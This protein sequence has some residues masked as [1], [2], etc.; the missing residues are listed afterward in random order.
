MTFH[1]ELSARTSPV[2]IG[3]DTNAGFYILDLSAGSAL[4]GITQAYFDAGYTDAHAS[5][6]LDDRVTAP[7]VGLVLDLIFGSEGVQFTDPGICTDCGD[8][9]DHYPVWATAY[10]P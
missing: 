9:S 2:I 1:L 3:G 8:F 7:E 6:E 5:S 10:L 4:D